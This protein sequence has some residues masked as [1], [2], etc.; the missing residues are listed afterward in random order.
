MKRCNLSI[1][2]LSKEQSLSFDICRW[3]RTTKTPHLCLRFGEPF[4]DL[5]LNMD[6]LKS[7]HLVLKFAQRIGKNALCD[8]VASPSSQ[9]GP[10]QSFDNTWQP[11]GQFL[12][13]LSLTEVIL[14]VQETL[15][16]CRWTENHISLIA[17]KH[18]AG[19][20]INLLILWVKIALF[21]RMSNLTPN[22]WDT[23]EMD[24]PR[25]PD[26]IPDTRRS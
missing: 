16:L 4:C 12:K 14:Q 9:V 6:T 23:V 7:P 25:K 13:D 2:F 5:L 21:S 10:S 8:A 17:A 18:T 24:V 19:M 22:R 15:H 26:S 3:Y 1:A 11:G 20:A